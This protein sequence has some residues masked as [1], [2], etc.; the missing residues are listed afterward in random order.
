MAI[1]CSR[2]PAAQAGPLFLGAL[3]LLLGL[4][5]PAGFSLAH[6]EE[7]PGH[8]HP[9]GGGAPSAVGVQERLGQAI[10]D[11][12]VMR[13]E[14]GRE[15]NV[16]ELVKIPTILVPVYYSCPNDCNLLLGSLAQVLPLVSLEP[17]KDFQV[18]SVSF[19]E[20]D[21]PQVAARRKNDFVTSM[22]DRFPA[23]NWTFLTGDEANIRKLT[24]AVGFGF[25]RDGKAFKHPVVLVALSPSGKVVRYLYGVTPLPF[26]IT[27][28]A[29]EAARETVGLSVRRAIAMCYSYDPQGR[30]Y[31]FDLMK[32]SGAGI[33]AAMALFGV[34][35]YFGGRKKK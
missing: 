12:I 10:P 20:Q 23:R 27:M 11:D 21:T 19:D 6:Q 18:V 16:K 13:D 31:V 29:T 7:Q 1:C 17:G 15:V 22:G 32:V 34:F 24:D 2:R 5:L 9:A 33:L 35:L 25:Q 8:E 26:D 30:Q 3:L 4:I 28:A 14:T